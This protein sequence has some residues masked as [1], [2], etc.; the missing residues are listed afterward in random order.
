MSKNSNNE[1][2]TKLYESIKKAFSDEDYS[3][4]DVMSFSPEERE[5]LVDY[6]AVDRNFDSIMSF[7]SFSK[8]VNNCVVQRFSLLYISRLIA[9]AFIKD[10]RLNVIELEPTEEEVQLAAIY[11]YAERRGIVQAPSHYVDKGQALVDITKERLNSFLLATQERLKKN[12]QS[13]ESALS[14]SAEF[15]EIKRI[16]DKTQAVIGTYPVKHKFYLERIK[17]AS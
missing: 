6:E 2:I 12:A 3:L 14:R 7:D 9:L 15:K 11:S 4:E 13:I 8:K 5:E 1:N 10:E 16:S 17:N